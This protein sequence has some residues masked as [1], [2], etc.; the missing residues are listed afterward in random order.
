M[1]RLYPDGLIKLILAV[2]FSTP[3]YTIFL[4]AARSAV[5]GPCFFSEPVCQATEVI[6]ARWRELSEN[7]VICSLNQANTL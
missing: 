1:L 7:A 2:S 3:L 4:T 5:P 6:T